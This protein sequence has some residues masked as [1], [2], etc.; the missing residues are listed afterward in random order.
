MLYFPVW[1]FEFAQKKKS[2]LLTRK[3]KSI[4]LTGKK[5]P[6]YWPEAK[7]VSLK[8]KKNYQKRLFFNRFSKK[9]KA[10]QKQRQLY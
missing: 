8:K 5:N 1:V 7:A 10:Y 3:K 2:V 9:K 6:F 4:L